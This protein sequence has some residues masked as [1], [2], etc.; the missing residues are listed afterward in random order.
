MS[1]RLPGLLL[2]VGTLVY[3]PARALGQGPTAGGPVSAPGQAAPPAE[4]PPSAEVPAGGAPEGSRRLGRPAPAPL[5]PP[6]PAEEPDVHVGIVSPSESPVFGRRMRSGDQ[7]RGR[8]NRDR[9]AAPLDP[10]DAGG[11]VPVGPVPFDEP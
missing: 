5:P 9:E 3:G 6:P 2:A 4:A 11:G 7:R 1:P 8:R 10:G